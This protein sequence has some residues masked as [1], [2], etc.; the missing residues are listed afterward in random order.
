MP[1][2]DRTYVFPPH[3]HLHSLEVHK[4][5]DD[6]ILISTNHRCFALDRHMARDLQ[7]ALSLILNGTYD[8]A[9]SVTFLQLEEQA[10]RLAE[11]YEDTTPSTR[12][13]PTLDQL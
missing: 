8:R 12:I 13:R 6:L 2:E 3:P 11:H 9:V 4:A 10:K 5:S 7:D 1:T